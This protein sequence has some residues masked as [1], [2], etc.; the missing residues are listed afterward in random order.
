MRTG[1]VCQKLYPWCCCGKERIDISRLV[2]VVGSSNRLER[3]SDDSQI[4]G[5]SLQFFFVCVYRRFWVGCF[6][7]LLFRFRP[8]PRARRTSK[9][10]KICD[11]YPC[12]HTY[13]MAFRPLDHGHNHQ[14]REYHRNSSR[15]EWIDCRS[16]WLV[17]GRRATFKSYIP[18]RTHA[19]TVGSRS[20]T[21]HSSGRLSRLLSAITGM[22][23]VVCGSLRSDHQLV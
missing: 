22:C 14:S 19:R 13:R 16:E 23:Y 20:L 10:R 9:S 4:K 17:A 15:V 6:K 5:M 1:I 18:L 3:K 8:T 2:R 7:T 12:M 11:L 21:I